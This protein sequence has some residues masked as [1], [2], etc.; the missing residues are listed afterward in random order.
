MGKNNGRC[1]QFQAALDH[2]ARVDAGAVDGAGKQ[3]FTVDDAVPVVQ[4]QAGEHLVGET[5]TTRP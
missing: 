5:G 2:L 4:E 1:V 3:D